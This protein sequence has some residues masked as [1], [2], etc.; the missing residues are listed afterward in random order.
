MTS[1]SKLAT[2]GGTSMSI[3]STLCSMALLTALLTAGTVSASSDAAFAAAQTCAEQPGGLPDPICT[4]G[5]LNPD[6]TPSTIDTTICVGGYSSSIR[7]STT[8]TNKLKAKQ[9]IAYGRA[10]A[11]ADYEEDHM[12][13]LSLGGSPTSPKNLWPQARNGQAGS[14]AGDKDA[15]E[16]KLYRA[17]CDGKAGLRE[18]QQAIVTDWTTALATLGL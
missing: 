15:V 2:V 4:P 17:V 13:N 16:F 14:T 11:L 8:F 9:M 12:I 3:R 7:P 1:E 18:A 6:V 5:A 10:G